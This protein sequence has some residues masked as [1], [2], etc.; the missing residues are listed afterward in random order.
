MVARLATNFLTYYRGSTLPV[1]ESTLPVKLP[2]EVE[3]AVPLVT[4]NNVNCQKYLSPLLAFEYLDLEIMSAPQAPCNEDYNRVRC[5]S[6]PKRMKLGLQKSIDPRRFEEVKS[7][8]IDGA[9]YNDSSFEFATLSTGKTILITREIWTVNSD[10]TFEGP[11][12]LL[13]PTT[14]A[15]VPGHDFIVTTL[16]Q[17]YMNKSVLSIGVV[18]LPDLKLLST[19]EI[20]ID[21]N[22]HAEFICADNSSPYGYGH[23]LVCT[24]KIIF[25]IEVSKEGQITIKSVLDRTACTAVEPLKADVP[26]SQ[27]KVYFYHDPSGNPIAMLCAESGRVVFLSMSGS[28]CIPPEFWIHGATGTLVRE[29]SDITLESVYSDNLKEKEIGLYL[30]IPVVTLKSTPKHVKPLRVLHAHNSRKTGGRARGQGQ[31]GALVYHACIWQPITPGEGRK[32]VTMGSDSCIAISNLDDGV[33][34]STDT[35]PYKTFKACISP[36]IVP[37]QLLAIFGDIAFTGSNAENQGVFWDLRKEYPNNRISVTR[38]FT[39]QNYKFRLMSV[40]F[41]EQGILAYTN[42]N[43]N[44]GPLL[45][46][47]IPKPDI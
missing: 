15:R 17:F 19:L 25:L 43:G 9:D 28:Q 26:F 36:S 24:P 2:L 37:V 16:S 8:D 4:W 46:L 7:V 27:I 3:Y 45:T 29:G 21:S 13:Q 22:G 33:T 5:E 20:N 41:S 32:L 47:I 35:I 31:D 10:G 6:M 38:E 1:R 42:S 34:F 12:A 23:V 14:F 44:D 39:S 11:G 18:T 40:S 30:S